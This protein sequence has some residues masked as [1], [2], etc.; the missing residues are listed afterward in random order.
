MLLASLTPHILSGFLLL[1]FQKSFSTLLPE[2]SFRMLSVLLLLGDMQQDSNLVKSLTVR[3]L[4][5]NISELLSGRNV[6]K[7]DDVVDIVIST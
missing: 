5:K 2:L 4:R 6:M 3:G 1:L 7:C